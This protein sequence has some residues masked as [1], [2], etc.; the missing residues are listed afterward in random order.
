MPADGILQH[1]RMRDVVD[2]FRSAA[3]VDEFADAHDLRICREAILEPVFHGLHVVIGAGLDGLDGFRIRH[4]EVADD[5][6][7][8]GNRDIR[9]GRALG[10]CGVRSECLEPLDFDPDTIADQAVFREMGAQAFDLGSIAAVERRKS[11]KCVEGHFSAENGCCAG[12][13]ARGRILSCRHSG[14]FL[15]GR[16]M[17]RVA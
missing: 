11:G 12:T 6:V 9:K 17:D 13:A 3:E 4:R 8:L 7:Q 16:R 15:S 10:D 14:Q 1:Q 5:A 2:V